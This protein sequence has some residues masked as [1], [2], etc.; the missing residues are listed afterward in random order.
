M[1]KYHSID[2]INNRTLGNSYD[3]YLNVPIKSKSQGPTKFE[4]NFAEKS[5]LRRVYTGSR[6]V[7]VSKY[8]IYIS[9]VQNTTSLG[10]VF[11]YNYLI[12]L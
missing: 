8:C 4:K 10:E 6:S 5:F 2:V 11:V 7:K 1:K 3:P 12:I 9:C